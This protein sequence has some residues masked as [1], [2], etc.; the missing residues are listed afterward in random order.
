M[1]AERKITIEYLNMQ[2]N[3]ITNGILGETFAAD[4]IKPIKE[5]A[6][7]NLGIEHTEDTPLNSWLK[8]LSDLNNLPFTRPAHKDLTDAIQE[9]MATFRFMFWL[10]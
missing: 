7:A 8:Y 5:R 2:S 1:N 4:R 6:L 10:A 3:D 9:N